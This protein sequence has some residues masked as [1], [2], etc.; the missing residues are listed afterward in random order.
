MLLA[1][2]PSDSR[3]QAWAEE[4]FEA[5]IAFARQRAGA[6]GLGLSASDVRQVI[7]SYTTSIGDIEQTLAGE[8]DRLDPLLRRDAA[9]GASRAPIVAG[10]TPAPAARPASAPVDASAIERFIVRW[11]AKELKL[12]EVS[13]DPKRSF[14]DYGLDSVTA[15]MLVS[16]LEEWLRTDVNPELPYEIPV[17]GRF[18]AEVGRRQAAGASRA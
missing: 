14:F 11:L 3:W 13:V 7:A 16:R 18:A 1:E 15:V 4:R 2:T 8:D 12:P 5:A 6:A 10:P 9:A 17:I